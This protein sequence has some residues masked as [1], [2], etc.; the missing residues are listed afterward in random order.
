MIDIEDIKHKTVGEMTTE[1]HVILLFALNDQAL[2]TISKIAEVF[3]DINTRIDAIEKRLDLLVS[4][5][6][7]Y[8]M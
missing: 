8:K 1:E 2:Q 7:P 4:S 3:D 5:T 6:L